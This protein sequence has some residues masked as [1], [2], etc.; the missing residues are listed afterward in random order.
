MTEGVCVCVCGEGGVSVCV[1]YSPCMS[2]ANLY[3]SVS[4]VKWLGRLAVNPR[5]RIRI[6]A[7]TIGAKPTQLLILYFGLVEKCV[8]E[9]TCERKTVGT[10][11]FTP[12]L[13]TIDSNGN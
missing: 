11:T 9:K 12:A 10:W 3:F 5:A 8:P 13:S 4:V 2:F 7:R 6:P 1:F